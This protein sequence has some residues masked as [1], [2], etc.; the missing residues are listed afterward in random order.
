MSPH[1]T[2]IILTWNNAPDTLACLESVLQSD[3]PNYQVLVVDNGSTDDSVAQ[4]RRR[5][6]DTDVLQNGENL[7]YAEG[8]NRGIERALAGGADYVLVLNNDTVVAPDMLTRLIE[9]ARSDPYAGIVGPV[10]YELGSPDKLCAA[11]ST[12]DWS[13]GEIEY[14]GMQRSVEDYS[15]PICPQQCDFLAGAGLLM[16]REC[17]EVVGCFDPE[18]YINFEDVELGVRARRRGF[19]VILVPQARLWHKVSASMGRASPS[20]TYYMTRNALRFFWLNAPGPIRG[21][22]VG[23]IL[24][25]TVRTIGAWTFKPCYHTEWFRRKRDANLLA[26]RDFFLGRFG[27]MG[28]DVARVC[29]S[30]RL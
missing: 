5:F 28:P 7:G 27:K 16:S 30:G 26:L 17:L 6:P 14:R 24:L 25:R 22:A 18:Y 15:M 9:V 29:Y 21:V 23:R 20:T 12:I 1:V 11:G 13:R 8:N 2:I 3:Y 4:I 10:I 19:Q